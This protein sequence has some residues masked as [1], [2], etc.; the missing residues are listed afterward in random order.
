MANWDLRP[1]VRDLPRLTPRLILVTGS[2]D[3]MVPP[4]EALSCPRAG[5]A[6]GAGYRCRGLGHLAHE[7]RPDEVAA[8]LER[9][10]P[11][12]AAG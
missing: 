3:G 8:L 7:E 9:M 11:H 4:A 10:V 2:K 12:E 5:A 6:G 1:L